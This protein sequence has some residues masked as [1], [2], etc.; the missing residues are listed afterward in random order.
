MDSEQISQQVRQF[1]VDH[2]LFGEEGDLSDQTLL[3]EEGI[4]DST[5]FLEL[6][7]FLER[8]YGFRIDKQELIPENLNSI[9]NVANFVARKLAN[10]DSVVS[11]RS[12]RDVTR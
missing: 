10:Q 4:V 5:G 2:F 1:I 9:S 12:R 7:A 3:L 11:E 8:T 6:T